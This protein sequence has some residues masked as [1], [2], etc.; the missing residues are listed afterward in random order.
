MIRLKTH[1]KRLHGWCYFLLLPLL[2]RPPR[3]LYHGVFSTMPRIAISQLLENWRTR[4]Q[5]K[6]LDVGAGAWTYPRQLLQDT[7][8]YTATDYFAHANV[9]VLSDIHTLT[10]VF[11]PE[12]FDFVLCLDVLEHTQRPW[13]AVQQLYAVL[14]PGGTLLLT[15]PFNFHVHETKMVK[16]YCRFS[17]EGLRYLLTQ[18]AGFQKVAITAIGHPKFPFS[19]TVVAE[20]T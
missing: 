7:C 18:V 17:A 19:Y 4:I 9:D 15:T 16:D 3:K 13:V 2:A 8:E 6:V 1:L 5:G 11:A 14:K 20:K 10:D 12:T